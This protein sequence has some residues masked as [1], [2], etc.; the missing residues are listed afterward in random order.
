MSLS[1][2]MLTRGA[3]TLLS[4]KFRKSFWELG[5]FP[6]TITTDGHPVPLENIWANGSFLAA[7]F[8]QEFYLIMN[9]AVGSTGGWFPD[10]QGNKPWLNSAGSEY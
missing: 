1:G 5:D 4:F 6:G 8:D 3:H 7:P 2:Y 9:V 10:G